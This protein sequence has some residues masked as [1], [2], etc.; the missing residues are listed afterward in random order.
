M[1]R[2]STIRIEIPRP[3]AQGYDVVIEV[4]A[5]ER[6]PLLLTEVAPA[7]RYAIIAD[8]VVAELHGIDTTRR[9]SAA[10]TRADLF[11]LPP[12]EAQKTRRRWEELT[13]SLLEAGLGRDACVIA[14]GGGVVGDLAGFVAATYLRGVP[15]VQVPTTLLSM[16]DASVGGKTGVDTP[17]GKNLVGVIRQPTVVVADPR[18]LRTLPDT[19]MRSGLAEALK[20]GAIA[21]AAYFDWILSR[22]QEL[23]TR[24]ERTLTSL[25]R[26]SVE[27]KAEF[28]TRD[29]EERGPRK[30]LNFGH[31]VGHALEALSGYE[32]PHGFAIGIGMELEARLGEA[33]GITQPGTSRRVAEA[34]Q[35]LELPARTEPM[36]SAD[37][38][39]ERAR[40]DKKVRGGRTHYTLLT[41]LGDVARTE[42]GAWAFPL[43]ESL[44][45]SVIGAAENV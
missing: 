24:Q 19:Q 42:S 29:P 11:T 37:R 30:A 17:L 16:I 22:R 9:L 15:L 1:S 10:G 26:R 31:T 44:V 7:A 2:T 33:A 35:A 21:D 43:D 23:L 39:V 25:V 13:D 4:G 38:I 20:H 27:I 41:R 3:K 6:L 34:L 45:K 8:E 36:P 18:V 28:V 14:L 40:L 32:L 5:L 12:G